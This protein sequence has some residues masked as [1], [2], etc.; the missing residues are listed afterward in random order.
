MLTTDHPTP[1]IETFTVPPVYLTDSK[2]WID[3]TPTATNMCDGCF[4]GSGSGCG[5]TAAYAYAPVNGAATGGTT[6]A[7]SP[8]I[9]RDQARI[10]VAYCAEQMKDEAAC[11]T[12]FIGVSK[13]DGRC[14]CIKTSSSCTDAY[15]NFLT[16]T[17]H[18]FQSKLETQSFGDLLTHDVTYP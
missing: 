7:T 8:A 3:A 17:G 4:F 18:F 5:S 13:S 14:Y 6:T 15:Q 12:E 1:H 10:S 16:S 11:S 2:I 9:T